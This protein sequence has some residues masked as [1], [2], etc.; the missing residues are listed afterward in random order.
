MKIKPTIY[1]ILIISVF[2]CSNRETKKQLSELNTELEKTK[3]ELN[4]CS[5]ELT[6]IKNTSENRFIKANNL[7]YDNKLIE[8]KAEF[9]GIV[10]N[11][12]GTNDAKSASKEIKKIDN[13]IKKQEIEALRKLKNE[14]EEF[15]RKKTLGYKILK[16][17]TRIEYGNLSLRFDKI[18]KGKRWS[19][20][21]YGYQYFLRDAERGN[22]HIMTRV[23]ITSENNNPK[24][25]PI[26]VYKMDNGELKLLGVLGYKF[27]RWKD[28]GSYLG[29]T[30]DYGNDF[31]HSKTIPFNCGLELSDDDLISGTIYVVLKKQGCFNRTKV[32]YGNPEIAYRQSLCNPKQILKVEDFESEYVLLKN[33]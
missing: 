25:P 7:L 18:W 3:E 14:R 26:L 29:N 27:R 20:D 16:P 30:A 10:L 32:N 1:L 33:L 11:Y 23:S 4:T 17:T 6:E 8:A 2:N 5:T 13:I 24:L 21:D 19:F 15:E 12:R 28:Y 31:A 22:S 9:E